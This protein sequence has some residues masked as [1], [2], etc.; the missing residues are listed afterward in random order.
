VASAVVVALAGWLLAP[1][2]SSGAVTRS[3]RTASAVT[4][5]ITGIPIHGTFGNGGTFAGQLDLS[6]VGISNG[7]LVGIGTVSG[8]A[9]RADGSV[10]GRVINAPVALPVALPDPTCQIL[11]LVLGPLDLNLLG[12]HV[13]LNRVVLD[14]TAE[15]GPGN[16]LGNLLC[17]VAHLLD[18]PPALNSVLR[19]L[20][21][22]IIKL[23]GALNLL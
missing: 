1:L 3:S 4:N 15:S 18:S 20:L 13:H 17:A 10:A 22:G 23:V 8:T 5:R 7:H 2:T 16:L 14:I 12:L 6:R 11:H 21:S 19:D 9:K